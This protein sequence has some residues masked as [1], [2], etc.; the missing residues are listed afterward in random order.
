MPTTAQVQEL[1]AIIA[2]RG[3]ALRTATPETFEN[4]RIR[5]QS[6]L[7]DARE[8]IAPGGTQ[9]YTAE[10]GPPGVEPA[11]W[12]SFIE[13]ARRQ[14]YS[15]VQE[16]QGAAQETTGAPAA[17]ASSGRKVSGGEPAAPA[18]QDPNT[19]SRLWTQWRTPILVI[20]FGGALVG[21]LYAQARVSK[22]VEKRKRAVL[23]AQE[24]RRAS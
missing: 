8:M 2:A 14:N 19:L 5:L 7:A 9:L 17:P 4:A 1:D 21:A 3:H 24:A 10:S 18:M 20:G 6:A 23:Q 11:V 22:L 16:T 15:Y 12:A 13:T